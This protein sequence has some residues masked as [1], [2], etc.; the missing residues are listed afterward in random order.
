MKSKKHTKIVATISDQRCE[1]EFIR[2]LYEAG[3]NV[4]RLNTAHITPETALM[5]VNNIRAVSDKIAILIDT[6]GPEVR[7]A[8]VEETIPVKTGDK[9]KVYGGQGASVMGELHVDYVNFVADV[10]VGC[11]VLIDDGE[12]ELVVEGKTD[13]YLECVVGNDGEI[14]NRKSVNVPG[15]TIKLPA[16][17]EKDKSFIHFAIE[18]DIEFIAHSFV[19]NKEDVLDIQKILDEHNSKCKIIAKIEDLDGVNNIDEILDH[20]YGV[21]VARGDLGIEIAAEKIPGIQRKLIKKCVRRRKPVIIATQM[22]HSMIKSPRPTRA[23]V[24]DVA[25]AIYFRTDAIMLSGETAYGDYPVE[26]VKVMSKIAIEAEQ[27]KSRRNDI[28]I[29]VSKESVSEFLAEAVIEASYR[30]KDVKAIVTDSL[31]GRMSRQIAAY[32]GKHTVFAKCHTPRVMRELALSYGIDAEV[33][34]SGKN[35]SKMVKTVLMQL[36]EEGQITKEDNVV[37]VGGSYGVGGGTSFMEIASVKQMSKKN[38]N[39]QK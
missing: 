2:S 37:Y 35:N 27:S 17:T 14:K 19:R 9:F 21:M 32:R 28:P 30:T 13:D 6:K 15:A 22:L 20:A 26:S 36:L 4:A 39:D 5:E 7:T 16:L 23:E 12:L 24:S 18:Q 33:L 8:G 31:T 3:M 25:N 10:S 11:S 1:V 34:K 38:I 29:A